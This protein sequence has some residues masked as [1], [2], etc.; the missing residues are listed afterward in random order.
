MLRLDTDFYSSTKHELILIRADD[1]R[2]YQGSRLAIDE[3][4]RDKTT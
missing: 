3:Y 4:L 1:Y 2:A